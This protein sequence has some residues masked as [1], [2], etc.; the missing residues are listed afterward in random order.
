MELVVAA[1]VLVLVSVISAVSVSNATS[2]AR[3]G[4]EAAVEAEREVRYLLVARV[5]TLENRDMARSPEEFAQ[6]QQVPDETAKVGW[7]EQSHAET[8]RIVNP[9]R[10]EFTQQ[11]SD[12]EPEE[13]EEFRGAIIG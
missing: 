3:A 6:L 13:D 4:W 7:A 5:T 2:N 11:G 1:I 10:H 9:L 8:E 12:L